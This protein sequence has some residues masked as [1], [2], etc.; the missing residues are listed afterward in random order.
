MRFDQLE[1]VA[2]AARD[3]VIYFALRIRS[4]EHGALL[5]LFGVLRRN[6]QAEREVVGDIGGA[7]GEHFYRNGDRVLKHDNR[8]CFRA[9]V[10]KHAPHTLLH[11]GKGD[12]R[13]RQRR[14]TD[15]L[16]LKTGIFDGGKDL[17]VADDSGFGDFFKNLWCWF[18]K[19][20]P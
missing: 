16:H 2:D 6:P 4:A 17:E 18:K 3:N 1:H 14:R 8:K 7:D 20:L 9:D 19:F 12:K 5:K 11:L 15:I 13:R 10:G